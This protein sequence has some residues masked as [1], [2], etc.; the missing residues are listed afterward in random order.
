MLVRNKN[1][2]IVGTIQFIILVIFGIF[3]VKHPKIKFNVDLDQWRSNYISYENKSWSV[4][5]GE[6]DKG[7]ID[8]IYGP[9]IKCIK[10]SYTVDISYESETDQKLK[11][12]AASG[13]EAHIK[14]NVVTL[15]KNLTS[16]SY[17]FELLKDIDNLEIVLKYNG[18]GACK[19]NDIKIQSN[20]NLIKRKF[21]YVLAIFLVLD[22]LFIFGDKI[23]TNK[24][25]IMAILGITFCTSIPLYMVGMYGGHD[26]MFHLM[27]IEGIATEMKYG[28]F[29]AR[30]QSLWMDGYGYAVSI[31]Y[32]D[33]MLYFPALLRLAGF[34]VTQCFK[35]YM[36]LVN[37][38]TSIISIYS[39]NRIFK[40]KNIA[41]LLTLVYMTS[42]Y[43]LEDMYVRE[44]VGEFTAMMFFP[45]I[46]AA[47]YGIYTET[48]CDWKVYKKNSLILALGMVGLIG[49]HIL[50]SE[51][52]CIV[53]CIIAICFFKRTFRKKTILVYLLAVV[54]TLGLSFYFL[55]PFLD[56]YMN[57]YM[58]INKTVN[59]IKTIQKSG[60]YLTQYFSFWQN[61]FGQNSA[62]VNERFQMSPGFV[63][64]MV[65]IVG[66][67]IWCSGKA[68]FRIKFLT[69]FSL[70]FLF[71]SS[72]LFP[73][74]FIAEYS[75]IGNFLA[76]VQF[77]WRYLGIVIIFLTLLLGELIELMINKYQNISKESVYLIIYMTCIVM[78]CWFSSNYCNNLGI[79]NYYDTADLNNK[80]IHGGAEYLLAN[81]NRNLLSNDIVSKNI[82]YVKLIKRVGNT[83]ELSCSVGKK[84]GEIELPLYN[85]RGYKIM[86]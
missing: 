52:I 12:Y 85:Y 83:I 69:L 16:L 56:Y 26:G 4:E 79:V 48:D 82:E 53:L 62:N 31:Y 7:E 23:K 17:D 41:I 78:I 30:I 39:F 9:Y 80:R 36:F 51:M 14:A 8:L 47:I 1:I 59:E 21:V 45:L 42:S 3:I 77:P 75:S 46:V 18:N 61:I 58:N 37:L 44:A 32:G 54:E 72:N 74:D 68:N 71:I 27:R 22:I 24:K 55:L 29:P 50:S 20:S 67:F 6:I 60:V 25:L 49:N 5:S 19:I 11:V 13:N 57:C 76:Q 65:L 10:G 40:K 33:L 64:V 73:W 86:D 66:L 63:L 84:E 70:F 28:N 34:S 43:R 38:G 81:T 35:I 2:L 15:S